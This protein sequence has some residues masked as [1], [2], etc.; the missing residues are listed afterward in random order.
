[1]GKK[2]NVYIYILN[3]VRNPEGRR[4][5][6]RTRRRWVDNTEMDLEAIAWDSVHWLSLV[7]DRDKWTAL[8]NEPSGCIK[9]WKFPEW[10]H[11][12]NS[13]QFH[14]VSSLVN[15]LHE[16]DDQMKHSLFYFLPLMIQKNEFYREYFLTLCDNVGYSIIR[17]NSPE[18]IAIL[19]LTISFTTLKKRC[20]D[21]CPLNAAKYKRTLIIYYIIII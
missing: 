13:A 11:K 12:S 5:Q 3:P 4:P 6:G 1:M 8:V 20:T 10:L 21:R 7:Q 9:R 2:S 19:P 16:T 18:R 14:R 15:Y 17:L